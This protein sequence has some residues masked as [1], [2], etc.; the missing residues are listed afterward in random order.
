L[1][2]EFDGI[3]QNLFSPLEMGGK[4]VHLFV[5]LLQ[6]IPECSILETSLLASLINRKGNLVQQEHL[7]VF[8]TDIHSWW[9]L[10]TNSKWN[11][12]INCLLC[13]RYGSLSMIVLLKQYV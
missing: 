12:V 7:A 4:C 2:Q 8:L 6:L 11:C 3:L 13:A 5:C 1:S 9:P 10:Y